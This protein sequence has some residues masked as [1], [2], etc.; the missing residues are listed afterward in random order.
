LLAALAAR[1]AVVVTDDAPISFLPRMVA[2]AGAALPV[3]LELVDGCGLLPLRA[4]D[5]AFST[6]HAFRRFLHQNL[7]EHLVVA[8]KPDPLARARLPAPPTI[9][10]AIARRWPP[11]AAIRDGRR[12]R[13]AA[14]P[15]DHAIGDPRGPG[16]VS[17]G[18][19]RRGRGQLRRF[20]RDHLAGYGDRKNALSPDATSGLSPYLHFGHISAHEVFA[21]VA[22]SQEWDPGRLN[23]DARRGQRAGW[24]GM[25]APAEGFL[26]ELVTWRE[27][28]FNMAWQVPGC[29]RYET[30]PA[31]ARDTLDEHARDPRP[32]VYD[33][34]DLAA[35]R[36]RDPL[37]NAAQRQLV[38][39][40]RIYGYLRMLWGK[41]ILAWSP[42]PRDAL[43]AMLALNDRYALDGRDPNSVSGIAWVLGRYDRAWGPERPI[44]GKIRY[45]SSDSAARKLRVA[46]YLATYAERE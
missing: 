28:G 44:F 41:H 27:V 24:W 18:G 45:M 6:A 25:S 36:T 31:W 38:R 30:L 33:I 16:A 42:T 4:A 7:P 39:E 23:V 9:P 43:A 32:H 40:G 12:P 13:L 35:A 11:S 22:A 37:W 1:S 34:A 3:R 26:D 20:V 2:A 17:G 5:R 46:D 14:L 19:A 15:I 29:D 21:A 10:R 8:P